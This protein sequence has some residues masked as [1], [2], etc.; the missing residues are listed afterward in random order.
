MALEQLLK[1]NKEVLLFYFVES[2][3]L[4][5]KVTHLS[6]S[7]KLQSINWRSFDDGFPN[8]F[9]NNAQDI[10]GQ[11]VAF[12]AFFPTGS[13]ECMEEE[14]DLLLHLPWLE[15]FYF[16]DHVLPCFETGMPLLKRRLHQLPDAENIS[17]AFPDDGASKRF[18]KQLQHFSHGL[19]LLL[20]ILYT[21]ASLY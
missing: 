19:I 5:R 14:G 13:F 18:Y 4:A 12:L 21:C 8:L 1:K 6:D 9:I 15:R 2:E 20:T 7:I 10:G 3:A 16:G 17:I 11:H